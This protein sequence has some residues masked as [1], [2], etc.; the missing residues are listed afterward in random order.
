MC[1][2][3]R[4]GFTFDAEGNPQGGPLV[5]L[6]EDLLSDIRSA[7]VIREHLARIERAA[8]D[9]PALVI[10]SAKELVESAAKII[11]RER[12][13][14][15]DGSEDVPKLVHRAQEALGVHPTSVSDSA[16]G[17]QASRKILGGLATVVVGIAE[18]RNRYGTG[19]G[20]A[21]ARMGLH[22]RH[23]HLAIAAARTWCEFM[24][25]TLQDPAAPWRRVPSRHVQQH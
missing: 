15:F 13:V 22:P 2:L 11:L 16:D 12:G 24:L 21:E 25:D 18:L 5:V 9:D 17:A 14:T 8:A 6:R 1:L 20:P 19:H 3:K 7:D 4:D 10:G 23:T